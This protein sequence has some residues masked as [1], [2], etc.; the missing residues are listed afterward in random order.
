[1]LQESVGRSRPQT[2]PQQNQ[3]WESF[4][5]EEARE[6]ACAFLEKVRRFKTRHVP[7]R[8]VHDSTFTNEFSAA[9]LEESSLL[10]A[11]DETRSTAATAAAAAAGS[12]GGSGSGASNGPSAFTASLPA[13]VHSR[14]RPRAVESNSR[15]PK[16]KSSWWNGLFK[17]STKSKNSNSADRQSNGSRTSSSSSLARPQATAASRPRGRDVTYV[18][19]TPT[20]QYMNLSE[21]QDLILWSPC[22]LVLV[23]ERSNYQVEIYSPPKVSE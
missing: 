8:G 15:R 9:F 14:T 5:R 12:G 20:A 18:K 19:D 3:T 1:M 16:S 4:C 22:R 10:M 17:W 11:S 13:D 7:A 6:A 2:Q 23:E 21:T